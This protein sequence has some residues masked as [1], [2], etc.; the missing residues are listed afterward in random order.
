MTFLFFSKLLFKYLINFFFVLSHV[1]KTFESPAHKTLP[2]A[3]VDTA[4]IPGDIDAVVTIR[5]GRSPRA[6]AKDALSCDQLDV[7]FHVGSCTVQLDNLFG[8]DGELGKIDG[9]TPDP[10]CS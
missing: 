10:I 3:D 1:Y 4:I 5:L 8:G 9:T 2:Y 6:G 7:K